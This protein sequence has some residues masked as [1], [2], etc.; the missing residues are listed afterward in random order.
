VLAPQDLSDVL[1]LL[2]S[3]SGKHIHVAVR[4]SRRKASLLVVFD[5]IL[6]P[7][8]REQS[9]F[10]CTVGI[11]Q[12]GGR[13]PVLIL[14]PEHLSA[15]RTTE[16]HARNHVP[17]RAEFDIVPHGSLTIEWLAPD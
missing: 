13:P 3:L 8:K 10:I 7:I 16:G 2:Q 4:T 14:R 1:A 9:A 5:G 11:G 15:F 12:E 6:G 17:S